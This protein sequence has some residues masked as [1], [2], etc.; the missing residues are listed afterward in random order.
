MRLASRT[1]PS[2]G[3]LSDA[4]SIAIK[5][6]LGSLSDACPACGDAVAA[7]SGATVS[8]TAR[9]K[10]TPATGHESMLPRLRLRERGAQTEKAGLAFSSGSRTDQPAAPSLG[11]A[12]DLADVR[13]RQFGAELDVRGHLVTREVVAAMRDDRFRRQVRSFLTT[14]I[15]TASPDFTSGTPTARHFQHARVASR[16][17]S[18]TSFG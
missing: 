6:L 5:I 15:L 10:D 9:D 18:S 7:D 17:I 1:S 8:R 3:R 4:I 14:K 11:Q 12:Q 2:W 16:Q 13:L